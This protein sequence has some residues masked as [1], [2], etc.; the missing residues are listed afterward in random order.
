[1]RTLVGELTVSP[2]PKVLRSRMKHAKQLQKRKA[3]RFHVQVLF[4]IYA[5]GLRNDVNLWK[6]VNFI[7]CTSSRLEW[8]AVEFIL[9]LLLF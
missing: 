3:N 1:M 4:H 9:L 2:R 8:I 6:S 5:R 7:Q